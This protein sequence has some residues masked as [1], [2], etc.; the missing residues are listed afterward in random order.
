MSVVLRVA[1]PETDGKAIDSYVRAHRDATPFHLSAWSRA[2]ARGCGQ[3]NHYLIAETGGVIS[4]VGIGD[5]E[6]RWFIEI[7]RATEATTTVI[8][9]CRVYDDY[10][11]SGSRGHQ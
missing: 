1:D 4:V 6:H 11:R 2:V 10:R 3:V 5:F 9:K 8:R 7:D